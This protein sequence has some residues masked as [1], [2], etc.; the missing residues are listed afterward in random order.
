[1]KTLKRVRPILRWPGGKSR[2]LPIILPMIT[3]HLCYVEPFAGGLAVL[4]AKEPS[5]SEVVNDT[6]GTL[7]AL[8]RNVQ[9]HSEALLDEIRWTL[10]GRA[11]LHEYLKQPG[12]TEIQRAARYL[13]CNKISFGG[14]GH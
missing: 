6:N 14:N 12:V 13:I 7:V 8:Y 1:M 2:H 10:N 3:P 9:Y 11:N 5:R 4:L